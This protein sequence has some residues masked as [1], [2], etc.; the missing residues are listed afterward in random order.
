MSAKDIF[1][2]S[3]SLP[4]FAQAKSNIDFLPPLV[5]PQFVLDQ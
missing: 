5:N 3:F 4:D 2:A 1:S